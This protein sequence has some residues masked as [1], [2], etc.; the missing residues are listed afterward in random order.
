MIELV[1]GPTALRRKY[2]QKRR[3]HREEIEE[4]EEKREVE[5]K[6]KI[7]MEWE[8][9]SKDKDIGTG[10]K[11]IEWGNN[12]EEREKGIMIEF[13]QKETKEIEKL[14]IEI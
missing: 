10:Q 9:G 3:R 11:W 1:L 2:S 13:S 5:W 4:R 7:N 8:E 14:L 6:R 12:E